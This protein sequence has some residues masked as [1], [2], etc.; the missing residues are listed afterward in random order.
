MTCERIR[1]LAVVNDLLAVGARHGAAQILFNAEIM[2]RREDK[3]AKSWTPWG[4]MPARPIRRRRALSALAAYAV[5]K[6]AYRRAV[7]ARDTREQGR[8]LPA[9][10]AAMIARLRAEV[11]LGYG[12]GI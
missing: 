9:L 5:V 2:A 4:P 8:I 3:P 12:E 1:L 10:N 11:A 6:D 7:V